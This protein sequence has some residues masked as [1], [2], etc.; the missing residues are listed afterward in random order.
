MPSTVIEVTEPLGHGGRDRTEAPEASDAIAERSAASSAAAV[1]ADIR[2]R[3]P[4]ADRALVHKLLY[5]VQGTHLNW[6]RRPAFGE[7]L[8][9][10]PQGPV[11]ASL[12]HTE[13]AG[14]APQA[15]TPLPES[16][17]NVVTNVLAHERS[18]GCTE[19]FDDI[20]QPDPW[21]QVTDGGRNVAYQPISKQRLCDYFDIESPLLIRL[22]AS[23][24]AVRDDRPFVPDPPGA[25]D[26]FMAEHRSKQAN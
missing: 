24:T 1:A 4:Q 23:I 14:Q 5:F 10:W 17:H 6:E 18:S 2:R 20:A 8:E 13:S 15:W 11:V 19:F 12:W 26:E 25:L 9:A 7:D 22:R 21:H 3:M 16:V